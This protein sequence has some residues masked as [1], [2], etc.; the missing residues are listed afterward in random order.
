MPLLPAFLPAS[1]PSLLIHSPLLARLWARRQAVVEDTNVL[2]VDDDQVEML[3]QGSEPSA[4][5]VEVG[6]RN[7]DS[8]EQGTAGRG[9]R[10]K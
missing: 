8:K 4:L 9:L 10:S 1:L 6:G 7:F 5:E 3:F 2:I